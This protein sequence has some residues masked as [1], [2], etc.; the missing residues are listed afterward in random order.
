MG[1][2]DLYSTF[3]LKWLVSNEPAK[4]RLKERKPKC[5]PCWVTLIIVAVQSCL[6]LF[7]PMDCSMSGFPVLYHLL[8]FAQTHV[9]QVRDAIQPSHLC[10]P[11]LLLSSVFPSIRVCS[12]K[13]VLPIRQPKYRSFSFSINPS[14]EY[15][16]LISFR[17]DWFDLLAV[18]GILKSLF[19]HHSSKASILSLLYGPTLTSIHDYWKNNSFDYT[20]LCWQSSISS[21]SYTV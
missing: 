18:Q 10:C 20:D 8:E 5:N 15:S 14:N 11:L 17:V 9:H 2:S 13:S 19:Q 21:F 7:D 6:T 12:N 16:G 1:I 3:P 4:E